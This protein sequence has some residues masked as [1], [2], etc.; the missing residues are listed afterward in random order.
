ML[1]SRVPLRRRQLLY[2]V[3]GVLLGQPAQS[4]ETSPEAPDLGRNWQPLLHGVGFDYAGFRW[5]TFFR[6]GAA[7]YAAMRSEKDVF[8]FEVRPGDWAEVDRPQ[9]PS[10]RSEID[11][12]GS[13]DPSRVTNIRYLQMVES[14]LTAPCWAMGQL[15]QRSDPDSGGGS[16]PL[17]IAVS[18]TTR[19]NI[20]SWQEKPLPTRIPT[21]TMTV[22]TREGVWY[23]WRWQYLYHP[24]DGFCRVWRNGILLSERRQGFGYLDSRGPSPQFGIYRDAEVGVTTVVYYANLAITVE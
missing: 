9:N 11:H 14:G 19:I 20:R 1:H 15:H 6:T 16:P 21:Q 10:Q 24:T 3:A 13:L 18:N 12:V 4:V 17:A 2:G 5:G 23:E 7:G 22:E 8:R